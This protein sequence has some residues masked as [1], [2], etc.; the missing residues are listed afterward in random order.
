MLKPGWLKRQ[1]ELAVKEYDEYPEWMKRA[2]EMDRLMENSSNEQS[3]YQH[4]EKINNEQ[5]CFKWLPENQL[6]EVLADR[7]RRGDLFIGGVL[8]KNKKELILVRGDQ[9]TLFVPLS[10]FK[11]DHF[12][13]QFD[14]EKFKLGDYG[15]SVCFENY[16]ASTHSILRE[17][18]SE[19]KNRCI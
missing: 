15:H 5:P 3:L 11:N 13:R 17:F 7:S 4:L 12:C 19:Y 18:D 10:F 9:R 2:L 8:H 16:E 6:K 1:F 14:F